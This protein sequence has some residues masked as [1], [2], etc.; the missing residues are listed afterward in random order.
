MAGTPEEGE[1]FNREATQVVLGAKENLPE[2]NEHLA[3]R[4]RSPY[5]K[6]PGKSLPT[7]Y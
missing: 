5:Q 4:D 1:S 7:P 6:P 2:F 3:K